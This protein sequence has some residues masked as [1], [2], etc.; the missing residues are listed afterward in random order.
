ML[1]LVVAV[2]LSILGC[3]APLAGHAENLGLGTTVVLELHTAAAEFGHRDSG[4]AD[5]C[6]ESQVPHRIEGPAAPRTADVLGAPQAAPDALGWAVTAAA[7]MLA[8]RVRGPPGPAVASGR[9]ILTRICI[10]RR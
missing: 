7:S 5:H 8:D 4:F 10:A 3:A 9:E 1:V 6:G 2:L